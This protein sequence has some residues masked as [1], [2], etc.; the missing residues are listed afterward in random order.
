[1]NLQKSK[2]SSGQE[3]SNSDIQRA[4]DLTGSGNGGEGA[5]C[6]TKCT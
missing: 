4:N 3:L 1:M 6:H 5:I 2:E